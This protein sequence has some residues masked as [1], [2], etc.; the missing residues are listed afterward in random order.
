MKCA[1]LKPTQTFRWSTL[2]KKS[3]SSFFNKCICKNEEKHFL[4]SVLLIS[5]TTWYLAALNFKIA[6]QFNV[7]KSVISLHMHSHGWCQ[8]FSMST[9]VWVDGSKMRLSPKICHYNNHLPWWTWTCALYVHFPSMGSYL[10]ER[11]ETRKPLTS[12]KLDEFLTYYGLYLVCAL[13]VALNLWIALPVLWV[14][15]KYGLH[16]V[17]L[18]H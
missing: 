14:A 9:L 8:I 5:I 17:W 1:V 10:G 11:V 3:F 13:P 16:S 12:A 18:M 2:S 6:Y 7:N 4:P 15:R